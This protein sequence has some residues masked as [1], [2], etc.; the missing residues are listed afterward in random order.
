MT[1]YYARAN[2]NDLGD[3]TGY[4]LT[5]GGPSAG[6]APTNPADR[7][8]FDQ[9]SGPTRTITGVIPGTY[10]TIAVDM[11]N[12]NPMNF[13]QPLKL[14][15]SSVLK[16][17]VPG[18]ILSGINQA[19]GAAAYTLDASQ[20]IVGTSGMTM[21]LAP[22]YW[23][24]V[25]GSFTSLGP[26]T[27]PT[28]GSDTYQL[29]A[30]NMTLTCASISAA[31]SPASFLMGL[32]GLT[33]VVTGSSGTV[34]TL[35]ASAVNASSY[36][37]VL[38]DAGPN[39][40]QVNL[41]AFPLNFTNNTG[42]AQGAGGVLFG[43]AGNATFSTFDAGKGAITTFQAGYVYTATNWILDGAGQY[44]QIK[45]SSP[46]VATLTKSGG[47]T[48]AA[49]FCNFSYIAVSGSPVTNIR[50]T[51]SKMVGCTGITLVPQTGRGLQFF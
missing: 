34:A 13:T 51:N 1:T 20:C 42:N 10:N 9:N 27:L 22:V 7:L 2:L 36:T 14:G 21:S 6:V 17:T 33:I 11:T 5:S 38:T 40:K 28:G 31:A 3:A 50:A 29:A 30:Q 41:S 46:T 45:S 37:L 16:G 49:N 44:N 4:S 47:G 8:I 15:G 24:L 32:G 18:L 12:G 26:V 39:V 19:S 23:Q 43:T 25:G 35:A 48:V